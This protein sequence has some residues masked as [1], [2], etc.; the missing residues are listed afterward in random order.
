MKDN[1]TKNNLLKRLS[2]DGNVSLSCLSVGVN[3]ATYYRWMKKDK[4]FRYKAKYMIRYGKET[5]S[6]VAK[7][8]LLLLIKEKNLQAIKYFLSHNDPVYKPKRDSKVTILHERN[9]HPEQAKQISFEDLLDG[10]EKDNKR[11]AKEL[12]EKFSKSKLGI[13]KKPDGNPIEI[14]E[15]PEYQKYIEDW[16]KAKEDKKLIT[17]NTIK[18]VDFSGK[19]KDDTSE[20]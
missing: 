17:D 4:A 14:D 2:K 18:F 10:A 16:Q 20:K 7:Q 8:A 9:Y 3:K 6:D 11:I 19:P 12:Y 5:V 1:E 13:P 15:I